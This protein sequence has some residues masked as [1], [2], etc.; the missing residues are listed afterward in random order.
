M[1]SHVIN[2]NQYECIVLEENSYPTLYIVSGSPGRVVKGGVS[3]KKS[4]VRILT[5]DTGWTFYHIY[6]KNL[7]VCLKRP[8]INDKRGQRWP[9][10]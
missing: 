10:L 7:N 2:S 9:I 8:K 3:L 1:A 5:P 4:W 6:C